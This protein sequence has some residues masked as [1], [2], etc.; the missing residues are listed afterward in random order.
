V[1]QQLRE[2][3]RQ[4][5]LNTYL[6]SGIIIGRKEV[7][8]QFV[9]ANSMADISFVRFPL[10]D[11][12]DSAVTVTDAELKTWYKKN[13][14]RFKQ[15]KSWR[16]SYVTF[17]TTPTAEDTAIVVSDLDELRARFAQAKNDSV[18]MVQ[19]QSENRFS[20]AFVAKNEI[21]PEFKALFRL[22]PGEVSETIIA[23]GQVHLLK[24]LEV[25]GAGDKA[26]YRFLDFNR[27]VKADPLGSLRKIE[28]QA[29]DF[30]FFAKEGSFTGQAAQMNLT[31]QTGFVSEG[32]PFIAGLGQSRQ[33]LSFL[34][35]TKKPGRISPPFDLQNKLVVLHVDEILDEGVRSF[36][37]VKPQ[38]ER[39]VKNEKRK[40]LV[41]KQVSNAMKSA[42]SV[43][44]VAAATGK[45]VQ[46]NVSIR[47]DAQVIPGA[48]RETGLIGRVFT[49]EPGQTTHVFEGENAVFVFR[50]N[51]KQMADV[52]TLTSAQREEIKNQL[53][54]QMNALFNRTW[55]EQLIAEAEVKDHR[56]VLLQD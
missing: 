42:S 29:D 53:K 45:M 35:R 12:A 9:R 47:F 56:K 41:A 22:K 21:R 4:Q 51:S 38:V 43:E 46:N 37:E 36:D 14:A 48:G 28:E 49:L 1:E 33:I 50:V 17:D 52:S 44:E 3:R 30:V 16:F 15:N 6:E 2:Q 24:L 40:K 10:S 32:N 34:E 23:D 19:N 39:F 18:F 26:E 27:T 20:R 11:I 7:E 5:K 13:E 55:V 31:V 25:K 54:Q 8:D